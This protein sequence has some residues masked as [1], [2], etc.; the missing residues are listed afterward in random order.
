[1][2]ARY[3]VP[4]IHG[5]AAAVHRLAEAYRELATAVDAARRRTSLVVADLSRAWHGSARHAI[6]R[7]AETFA[8]DAAAL[9]RALRDAADEL[10]RYAAAL[11]RAREH[12]GFSLHKLLAVGAVVVVSVAAVV[13]TLGAASVVEAAA[14]TAAVGVA[15]DAATAAGAADVAAADGIGEAFFG[16]SA[17]RP[18]LAFVV[19]HLVQVEWAAGA[20]ATWD[21]LTIGR[22]RWRGIAVTGATAFV[23]SAGAAEATEAATGSDWM[24]G[25]PAALRSAAPHLIQGTTWSAAAAADDELLEHRFDPVDVAES[26]ALAGGSTFARDALRARGAWPEARD[27]RREALIRLLHRRGL[28]VDAGIAREL[29]ELRQPAH[30]LERGEIDLRMHEGPGHTIDRHISKSAGE[31]LARV[32]ASRI[33]AAS[34]YWDE[35]T[36]HDAVQHTL[37]VHEGAVRRWVA[38]GCPRTLRL[39]VTVPY[40][41]GFA[42]DRSG[43]VRFIRQAAVILRRDH[44]GIVVVTSYPLAGGRRL[45]R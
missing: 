22:L 25:A 35:A 7:P 34:T 5:D 15:T 41:V 44:A 8:R 21:E 37:V 6:D 36:A 3:V 4:V 10:D 29:A 1:M 43:R 11:A 42:V 18:L 30:E 31:L 33:P 26:F 40:D 13:V 32:R 20:M 19:P 16:L 17:M 9:V 24:A 38:A 23:A 2:T 14:A 27:Y 28:V 39:R 12:H 45:S